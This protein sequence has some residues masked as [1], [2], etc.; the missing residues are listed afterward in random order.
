MNYSDNENSLENENYE[1]YEFDN[2][3]FSY[4]DHSTAIAGLLAS[5]LTNVLMVKIKR[6]KEKYDTFF[7]YIKSRRKRKSC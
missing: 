4:M 7:F 1:D 5:D 3:Y 6:N 2:F